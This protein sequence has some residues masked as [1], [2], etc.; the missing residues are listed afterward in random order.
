MAP[1]V[2]VCP[3]GV[4][5]GSSYKTSAG[6]ECHVEHPC[7]AEQDVGMPRHGALDVRDHLAQTACTGYI[8][9]PT[10]DLCLRLRGKGGEIGSETGGAEEAR[11]VKSC[12]NR[13][14]PGRRLRQV[15][16]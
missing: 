16:A 11:D 7:V 12:E 6:E 3:A 14:D 5:E 10:L 8:F 9:E 4:L 1:E 2:R 13:M 15:W